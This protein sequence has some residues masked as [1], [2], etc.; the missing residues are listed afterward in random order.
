MDVTTGLLGLSTCLDSV[1]SQEVIASEIPLPDGRDVSE[2]LN[3]YAR[4]FVDSSVCVAGGVR[5]SGR[6]MLNCLCRSMIDEVYGFQAQSA[7]TETIAIEGAA[8]GQGAE[9]R[10]QIVECSATPDTLRLRMHVVLE[11][12]AYVTAP[13]TTPFVTDVSGIPGLEKRATTLDVRRNA[14]LADATLRL[15]EEA[16]ANGVIRVLVYHGAAQVISTSFTGASNCEA[17]GKLIVSLLVETEDHEVRTQL[18]TLPFTCSFDAPYQSGARAD[19]A[20]ESLSAVAADISFGVIDVEATLRIRLFGTETAQCDVLLD[21]Y[22]PE[23]A[24]GCRTAVLHPLYFGGCEQKTVT[25]S[26]SVRIPDGQPDAMRGV[27]A[28]VTPVVT[29]LFARDG[30]LSADVMLLIG[31]V[32]R[33]DAGR[34]HTCKEEI[35][36]TIA[37]DAPFTPD[38]QVYARTLSATVSGSGR[39]LELT[40]AMEGTA[41]LYETQTVTLVTAMTEETAPCPYSGVLIYCASADET[42]WD[43]GKRFGVSLASLRQWNGELTEPL[44]E[45][46][47]VV[48]LK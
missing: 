40:A 25:I 9:V 3:I 45:G 34:L 18:I 28:A 22:A 29:G 32:Y 27:Y 2:V 31:V 43:V 11:L 24:L 41:L 7:F 5:V 35:P 21:A 23:A 26:E 13:V 48:L 15:R 20:V 46:Q 33:C 36:V 30:A 39:M 10:A 37:F 14:Q 17:A 42:L 44:A 47:A 8:E 4:V 12:A 38:A 6:L 16:D 19:C 1:V